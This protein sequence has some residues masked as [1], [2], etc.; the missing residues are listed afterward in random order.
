[1]PFCGGGRW[2]LGEGGTQVGTV[3][4]H[5]QT[6][7]GGAL[8]G[9]RSTLYPDLLQAG[10]VR[11]GGSLHLLLPGA[12]LRWSGLRRSGLRWPGLGGPGL[13]P[14]GPAGGADGV[15]RGAVDDLLEGGG[16]GPALL[17][18]NWLSGGVPVLGRASGEGVLVA[19]H[20]P[21]GARSGP[22]PVLRG[23]NG[24]GVSARPVDVSK[25]LALVVARALRHVFRVSTL[26]VHAGAGA[27]V[28]DSAERATVL[29]WH[30]SDAE[31]VLAAVS[32]VGVLRE[33]SGAGVAGALEL[34]TLVVYD[35]GIGGALRH[36]VR[37]PAAT[38]HRVIGEPWWAVVLVRFSV[39]ALPEHSAVD[40][41]GE[42]SVQPGAV[43]SGGGRLNLCSSST[44]DKVKFS[45]LLESECVVSVEES[46]AVS[47]GLQLSKAVLAVPVLVTADQMWVE[48]G[49][50]V[51][52]LEVVN[53][54][55]RGQSGEAQQ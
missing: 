11:G 54:L 21:G 13:R 49:K 18:S 29:S 27:D 17:A 48:S 2:P 30:S 8:S 47:T 14:A 43:V 31:E 3:G 19:L 22:E 34:T 52:A 53:K 7:R 9:L 33:H 39:L 6:R 51:R 32:G 20:V 44:V 24:S 35:D 1:M 5:L 4:Q 15:E 26:A 10:A 16:G 50:L 55:S 40:F 36:L 45:T 38:G 42:G 25:V 41:V 46:E 12:E 37:P 28:E 23:S